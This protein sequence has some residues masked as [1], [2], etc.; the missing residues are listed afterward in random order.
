MSRFTKAFAG[1]FVGSITALATVYVA[2]TLYVKHKMQQQV[3]PQPDMEPPSDDE[4]ADFFD[5]ML[6]DMEEQCRDFDED[7]EDNP[8]GLDM[9]DQE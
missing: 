5:E 6:G 8:F 1:G 9:G 4:V 7:D 3:Q 2:E